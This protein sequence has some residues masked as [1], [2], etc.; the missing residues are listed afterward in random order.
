[1]AM[2][3]H[4]QHLVYRQSPMP[5]KHNSVDEA[6]FTKISRERYRN[7]SHTTHE[8]FKRITWTQFYVDGQAI[9]FTTHL[10]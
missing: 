1:M 6:S 9:F 10:R 5:V 7:F 2:D 4:T 3:P 8:P